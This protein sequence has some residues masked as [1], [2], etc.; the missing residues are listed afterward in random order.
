MAV[1]LIVLVSLYNHNAAGDLYVMLYN[2]DREIS[3][4]FS[5]IGI[6][7]QIIC[8]VGI[9]AIEKNMVIMFNVVLSRLYPSQ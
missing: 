5:V 1:D 2:L 7:K 4:D 9:I 8:L 6:I 3:Y